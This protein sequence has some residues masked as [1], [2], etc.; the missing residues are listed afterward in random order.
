MTKVFLSYRR[1]D[2]GGYAGRIQD[3]LVQALGSDILFM[4]VDAIPLG[5]NFVRVLHDE[6]A[7]CEV[8]LAVIGRNWLDARDEH[9][10]HRLENPN[11]FVRVEIGAALQ[12]DIPV[13]PILVDGARI[14]DARQ[15]PKE[16]EELSLRNGIE[17]RL[18]S[19][20][21][22]VSRLIR[23]LKTQLNI[24]LKRRR[25][26]SSLAFFC[27][28]GTGLLYIPSALFFLPGLASGKDRSYLYSA[29]HHSLDGL[30]RCRWS[31]QPTTRRSCSW[32]GGKHH[33]VLSRC[34]DGSFARRQVFSFHRVGKCAK[35]CVV[36]RFL[37]WDNLDL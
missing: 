24:D 5:A 28:I 18:A 37:L 17:V 7:K 20:H 31:A 26:I 29:F 12:R 14:P 3:Q 16:L 10:N 1:E 11:D 2:S 25:E 33:S 34:L 19:F 15:L 13:V 9:G 36:R 35:C 27:A 21:E 4:D 32:G 8:L 22:D 6:V 30:R 23:G